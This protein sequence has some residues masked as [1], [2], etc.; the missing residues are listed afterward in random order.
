MGQYYRV[1]ISN[2][3]ERKVFKPIFGTKLTEQAH[4]LILDNGVWEDSGTVVAV[5][6]KLEYSPHFIAWV[7]DYSEDLLDAIPEVEPYSYAARPKYQEVFPGFSDVGLL[8]RDGKEHGNM[9][10]L[11]NIS[12]NLYVDLQK[13]AEIRKEDKG[14]YIYYSPLPLL[15]A[16]GNGRGGGDYD[17]TANDADKVGSWAWDWVSVDS[18]VPAGF[19]K[20]EVN[21]REE[22]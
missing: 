1:I 6:E 12:K 22:C 14:K 7:G 10:Y 4:G 2:I 16:V 18:G 8:C 11:L 3:R 17:V 13:L 15:T 21:F 20:L 9:R 19:K 5:M